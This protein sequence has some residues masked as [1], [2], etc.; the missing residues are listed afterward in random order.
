MCTVLVNL[1]ILLGV[2]IVGQALTP[3]ITSMSVTS[4]SRGWYTELLHLQR[5][6][7]HCSGTIVA[8]NCSLPLHLLAAMSIRWRY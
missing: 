2:L 6:S 1:G 7:W 3:S 4:A 5:G 8:W